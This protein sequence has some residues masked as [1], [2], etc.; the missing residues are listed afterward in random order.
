MLLVQKTHLFAVF[1]SESIQ[2][3]LLKFGTVYHNYQTDFMKQKKMSLTFI[4]GGQ[5]TE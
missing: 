5:E 4:C 1:P 3:V 2:N